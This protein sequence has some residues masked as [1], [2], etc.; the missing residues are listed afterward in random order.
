MII[1]II[2]TQE[3]LSK[4]H[5]IKQSENSAYYPNRKENIG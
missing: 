4:L 2:N 3:D 1:C 5:K